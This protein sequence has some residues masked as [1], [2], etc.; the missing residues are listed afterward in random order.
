[1]KTLLPVFL[2]AIFFNTT[3]MAAG[4]KW[5]SEFK[6]AFLDSCNGAS[7]MAAYCDCALEKTMSMYTV[8]DLATI[9]MTGEVQQQYQ[10]SI[11]EACSQHIR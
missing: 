4:N 10:Q 6:K 2:V 1:M 9:S 5:D 8:E 11:L 3:S 7:G